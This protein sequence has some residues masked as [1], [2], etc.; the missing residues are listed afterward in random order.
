M[1]LDAI[2][3]K[4]IKNY[5]L[6]YLKARIPDFV[7]SSQKGLFTCPVCKQL[8]ANIYPPKSGI[9]HCFTPDCQGKI[10]DIFDICRTIDFQG[11]D[12]KDEDIADLLVEELGI[13]TSQDIQK[14]FEKYASWGWSLVP[15]SPNKNGFKGKEANIEKEWE[16]KEHKNIA[17]WLEWQNAELNFGLHAGKISNSTL[18][19]ID[20]KEI[21][22]EL[23]K[24]IGQTLTQTTKKGFHLCYFY[25]PELPSIDLRDTPCALPVEIRNASGWQTVIFPSIVEGHERTWNDSAPTKMPDELKSWLLERVVV[26]EEAKQIIQ[27]ASPA[28]ILADLKIQGLEG[29]CNSSFL[30]VGGLLRKQ[31]NLSQTE[32]T[33]GLLNDLLLDTPMPKKDLKNMVKELSKYSSADYNVLTKQI[34]EY[35]TKHNECSARDLQDVLKAEKKDIMECLAQLMLDSKAYKQRTLYKIIQKPDWKQEFLQ[36]SQVLEYNVPYF[37]D[38]AVFRRGDMICLGAGTGIGKGHISMNIIK[39]YV[40]QGIKPYYVSSEP[41][42]RFAQIAMTLGLKEGDFNFI[43][44]YH[45]EQLELEDDAVTI[46]DWI[47]PEEFSGTAN[48]YKIFA[49]Q[50]DRHAGLLYVFSQL[51]DSGEFYA[52]SMVRFFSSFAVKYFYTKVNGVTDNV[53]T[54]FKTNKIREAKGSIQEVTIPTKFNPDTK[55]LELRKP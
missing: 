9:V 20:T 32:Y 42:N 28:E 23:Q 35:L 40:E 29:K 41:G 36:E 6:D 45:P 4:Q 46:Y 12:L 22:S 50:L 16:K 24:F 14:W 8:S 49:K 47:L 39:K 17:E 10:G 15:V 25:E 11:Q 2:T 13:K 31:L 43:N 7:Q 19:D 27:E 3:K 5:I 53:N 48:L 52:S 26:K 18:I 33:L 21:P 55:E 38:V 1:L 44:H 51:N 30:K 37:Q 54:Y 34:L